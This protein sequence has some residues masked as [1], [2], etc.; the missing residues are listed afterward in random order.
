MVHAPFSSEDSSMRAQTE[1]AAL[2]LQ[3]AFLNGAR[4]GS[5]RAERAQE[6]P[7]PSAPAR[8]N[9]PREKRIESDAAKSATQPPQAQ[10]P[11][12]LADARALPVRDRLGGAAHVRQRPSL[13]AGRGAVVL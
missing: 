1:P 5:R 6:L 4:A 2:A 3:D 12:A 9:Q 11:Q 10:P 8:G 7:A 13:P